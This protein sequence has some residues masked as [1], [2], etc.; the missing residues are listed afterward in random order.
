MS[1]GPLQASLNLALALALALTLALGL[2]PE[3]PPLLLSLFVVQSQT[4]PFI[5]VLHCSV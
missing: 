4:T 3:F 5:S 1:L 2:E